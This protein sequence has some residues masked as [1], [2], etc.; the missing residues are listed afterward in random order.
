VSYRTKLNLDDQPRIGWWDKEGD[1]AAMALYSQGTALEIAAYGRRYRQALLYRLVTG[2]DAPEI[3]GYWL[4]SRVAPSIGGL[5]LANYIEPSINVVAAALEVFENRIGTLRPFVQIIPNG[6]SF[7]VREACSLAEHYTDALFDQVRLYEKTRLSFRDRGTWG[8]SFIKV[9]P[10]TDR[11]AVNVER[12]LM[13]EIL[14]D[15]AAATR[16]A[17]NNLIQRRYISRSEAYAD[18]VDTAPSS[19]RDSIASAIRRAPAAFVGTFWAGADPDPKIALLEGWKLPCGVADDDNDADEGRHILALATKVISRPEEQKWERNHFPF[20]VARWQQ[21]SLGYWGGSMAYAMLPYQ[22]T[23]NKHVERLEANLDHQAFSGWLVDQGVQMKAEAF[24]GRPGRILRKNGAGNVVPI[25]PE[26]NAGDA[27]QALETW[28]QRAYLR[29]GLNQQQIA[30][31]KQPGLTS[32]Q[33]LRTMVQIE[34]SRN[35]GLQI[36]GEMEVRDIA[37]L[38]LEAA[39]DVNLKIELPGVNGRT[40]AFGD[41]KLKEN[42]RK[43]G[44]FPINAL[45][46]DPEGR[47]QQI[48]EM[49][50]DGDID[51]RTKM[52]LREMPDLLSFAQLATAPEDLVESQLDEIVRTGK[53]IAPEPFDDLATAMDM[54]RNRY[55]LEKR[56]KTPAK[57]L[58]LLQC[59]MT[60]IADM[61]TTGQQF[62]QPAPAAPQGMQP[63]AGAPAAPPLQSTPSLA[64]PPAIAA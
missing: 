53:Y 60:A 27:Y 43:I 15:S 17:P 63:P 36:T 39:E 59:Y 12:V 62:I 46:N 9:T 58:R 42:A 50:A 1:E 35:K 20:A 21:Q 18:F 33:A 48:A 13:D 19:E 5:S 29:V 11:K 28:I 3:F 47:Q 25:T 30:G 61:M 38:A 40:I 44:V 26:S 37:M 14:I 54:S 6:G 57:T 45:V 22:R 16:G 34:D 2:D 51:K 49:Y 8:T 32:G 56:F 23:I 41:L 31:M 24:G 64:A 7:Q 10:D 4:S 55:W 52:R